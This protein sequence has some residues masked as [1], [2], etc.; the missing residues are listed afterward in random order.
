MTDLRT[1]DIT[2]KLI[3]LLQVDF[4]LTATPFAAMSE[5]LGISESDIIR[6]IYEL[7]QKDIVRL[8]GPVMEARK[9]GYQTTLVAMS[10]PINKMK[11]AEKAIVAHPSVSHAYE[12]KHRFNLWVTFAAPEDFDID[13]EISR[14]SFAAGS[15]ETLSLP[16]L[17]VFKIGAYFGMGSEG[18]E[19]EVALPGKT[20][21]AMPRKVTLTSQEKLVLNILQQDLPLVHKPFTGMAKSAGLKTSDFL[22]V[23]GSLLERGVL[24]RY[25]ASINHH[26]AGYRANA[27]I[28]WLAPASEVERCGKIMADMRQVSHCYERKTYVS[29]PYNLYTMVHARSHEACRELIKELSDSTGLDDYLVLFSTREF[30]KTRIKYP[31]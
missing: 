23:C 31:V 21:K 20:V 11:K 24:R 4:P 8:I 15:D 30:K 27:M 29:W 19:S 28:C 13:N 17:R 9:L 1:D 7:K 5:R 18:D 25:S 16:A 10:V 14:L 6:R 2:R 12:R 26:N 22:A 3:N